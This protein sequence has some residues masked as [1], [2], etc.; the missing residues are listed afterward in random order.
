MGLRGPPGALRPLTD[1]QASLRGPR[2][3]G[4]PRSPIEWVFISEPWYYSPRYAAFTR[5]L[6]NSAWPLSVRVISPVS[7]T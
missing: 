5:S 4:G 7:M 6:V 1:A 2:L 3:P